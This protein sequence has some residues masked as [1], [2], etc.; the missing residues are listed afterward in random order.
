MS[1]SWWMCVV[2]RD[3]DG[4]GGGRAEGGG[5]YACGTRPRGLVAC[6]RCRNIS[7]VRGDTLM[8]RNHTAFQVRSS[9]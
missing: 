2:R 9:V 4:L 8:T 6:Q 1:H 3:Y 7:R 5:W